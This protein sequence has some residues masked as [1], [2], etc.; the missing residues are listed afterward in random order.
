MKKLLF[1]AVGVCFLGAMPVLAADLPIKSGPPPA[2]YDWNGCYIGVAGGGAWGKSRH[3]NA[4]AGLT[5]TGDFNVSGAII[6]GTIGCNYQWA[7][8]W[9]IGIENDLS[10]TNKKGSQAN[11]APFPA[12]TSTTA[13]NWLDT[14]RLR[15]GF[16]MGPQ[17]NTLLYLTGGAAFAGV[18]V[19]STEG[20]VSASET[21]TI[22]GWTIGGGIEW[23]FG[24]PIHPF[25]SVKLEYLFVDLGHHAFFNP[26]PAGISDR[27]AG[28]RLTDNIVRIGLNWHF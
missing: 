22:T 11:L 2:F 13:E 7:P 6:G 23:A 19:S 3:D 17:N 16:L 14:L 5:I 15:L 24:P 25:W 12:G 9:L 27:A 21:R 1:S 18:K 4:A 10:W 28:V 20:A 26:P 8:T